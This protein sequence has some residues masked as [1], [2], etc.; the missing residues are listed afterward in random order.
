MANFLEET[1]SILDL[2]QLQTLERFTFFKKVVGV[3]EQ[4][5]ILNLTHFAHLY[6]LFSFPRRMNTQSITNF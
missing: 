1:K 6:I 2:Q 4:F 5:G 3:S